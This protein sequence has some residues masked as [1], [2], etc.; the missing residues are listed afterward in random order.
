MIKFL[1][2]LILI[3]IYT[4]AAPSSLQSVKDSFGNEWLVQGEEKYL[5]WKGFVWQAEGRGARCYNRESFR[6]GVLEEV[7]RMQGTDTCCTAI[8]LLRQGKS[9]VA[10]VISERNHVVQTCYGQGSRKEVADS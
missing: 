5:S 4:Y 7:V 8:I 3:S 2:C 10:R 9:S 6:R 1:L